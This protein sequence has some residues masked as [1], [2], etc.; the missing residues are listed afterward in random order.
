[1]FAI[2]KKIKYSFRGIPN[3]SNMHC[4][5]QWSTIHISSIS[6]GVNRRWNRSIQVND[7]LQD[8]VIVLNILATDRSSIEY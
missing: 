5:Q 7:P 3:A 8:N 4:M 2:C 1:M 6:N